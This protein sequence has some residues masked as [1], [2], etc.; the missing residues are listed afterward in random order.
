MGLI[1][2]V[3][4]PWKLSCKTAMTTAAAVVA[5]ARLLSATKAARACIGG[6]RI[7]KLPLY[8]AAVAVCVKEGKVPQATGHNGHIPLLA[9]AIFAVACLHG[10]RGLQDVME[11]VG[12]LREDLADEETGPILARIWAAAIAVLLHIIVIYLLAGG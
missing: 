3:G 10:F 6:I 8:V 1:P 7:L 12:Q 2:L 11:T 4:G 9:V 5:S